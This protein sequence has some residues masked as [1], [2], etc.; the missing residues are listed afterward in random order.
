MWQITDKKDWHYL[1]EKFWWVKIM[2]EVPQDAKHHAEGNV[3]IHTQMVLQ[4]LEALEEY[5]QLDQQMQEVLW[6]A[7]LL[8]D[9][10]KY[11]TTVVEPDGTI[12]SAG[13]ARKG[14]GAARHI[15]YR[16]IA[17]PFIMREQIAKLV[18]YHGL[19]LWILEK[20]DPKRSLII[21]SLE[22][23][24]K[25]LA[26]LAKADVLGRICNDQQELLYR[27]DCFIELCK[28]YNCWERPMQFA[29]ADAR[30][31]YLLKNGESPEYVPFEQPAV[32]VILMSGLPGAG[33][34]TYVRQHYK[35][36]PV[37][38]LDDIRNEMKIKPDDKSGNGLVIQTAKEKARRYLRAKKSFV[39]NATNITKQMRE[40]LISLFMIYDT[41]VKIVYVE[42]AANLLLL[43]NKQ[44]DA[45]VPLAVMEK[46]I[47]KLEV[48]TIV[49]AH[50][51][52]YIVKT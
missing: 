19:P 30:A 2:N 18:R 49:E 27:I 46:L 4:A 23:D 34:D 28:E 7:A 11:S 37:I 39:W 29:S 9:V 15:L 24:L 10:E 16:D 32:E 14:E 26:L 52:V 13:H 40:Q 8:H 6:A 22:V 48:P 12:S 36:L 5:Q 25:L 45:V 31:H 21:A 47:G 51:V 20:T 44:R 42:V 17:T 3:A 38:S 41:H 50:E 1:E 43:Q 35:D 33:K